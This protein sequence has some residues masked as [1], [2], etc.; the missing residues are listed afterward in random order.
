MSGRSDEVV[1]W[2]LKV[3][4]GK[5]RRADVGQLETFDLLRESSKI[6]TRRPARII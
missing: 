2:P 4:D 5:W 6:G 3:D 1:R